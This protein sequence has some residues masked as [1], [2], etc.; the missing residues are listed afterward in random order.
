MIIKPL[1]IYLTSFLWTF[2]KITIAVLKKQVINYY[3]NMIYNN[4]NILLLSMYIN[5]S[6]IK[7]I[8]SSIII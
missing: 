4:A 7:K 1:Y 3:N 5:K 2:S 8:R 6:S